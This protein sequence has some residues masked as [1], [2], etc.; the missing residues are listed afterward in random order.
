MWI[1]IEVVVILVLASMIRTPDSQFATTSYMVAAGCACG[2]AIQT[3][4]GRIRNVLS[5]LWK[6]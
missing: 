3:N 5:K 1:V 4:V 6:N 2:F